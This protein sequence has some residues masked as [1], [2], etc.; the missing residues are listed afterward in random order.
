VGDPV[1][2]RAAQLIS[3]IRSGDWATVERANLAERIAWWEGRARPPRP[4]PRA[5]FEALVL[6]SLG[7]AGDQ[8][9]IR[10]EDE[11]AIFWERRDPCPTLA[12]CESLGLDTRVVCRRV[13][14]KPAQMFLS[15][16][17]PRLR[18]VR[19]YARL[20]PRGSGCCEG[21]IR[22]D[23]DALMDIALEEARASRA[24][25]DKGYGAVVA[26][27]SDVVAR[28]HDTGVTSRDPSLHAEVGAI[29]AA[30]HA[31]GRA[32]LCGAVLV[33][34]C[35][36]CPMCSSLAVWA[37]LTSIVFGASIEET[38][39]LGRSRIRV[40][41]EEIVRRGPAIVEVIGGVRQAECLALYR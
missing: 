16:I 14:E 1:D 34:T 41:A 23:L 28:A 19:D 4:T 6:G 24:G 37:N 40:G 20:R 39:R 11:S 29:R 12:A 22:V 13:C 31:V 26:V 9:A 38:V 36:P 3:Q 7:V 5:G 15:H 8:I 10:S 2:A 25:G 27:G 32:D 30:A 33:S 21:I 18:F 35:E 17:D